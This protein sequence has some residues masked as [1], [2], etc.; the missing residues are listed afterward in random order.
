MHRRAD[1]DLEVLLRQARSGS[2]AARGE[3]LACY[4]NYLTL[5]ARL[6]LGRRLWARI[7]SAELVEETLRQAQRRFARFQGDT[8]VELVGWLRGI[9][10]ANLARL[11][12]R[13]RGTQR[14]GLD[15]A[16]QMALDLD[17]SS[18]TLHQTGAASQS[19][20]RPQSVRRDASVLLVDALQCL[21]DDYR[22]V[23]I[24]RQLEGLPFWAV[25]RRLGRP[26]ES[27][28]TLWIRA[29]DRLHGAL[30]DIP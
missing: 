24:L 23:I 22:E 30:R 11:L 12:R 10:A 21:P 19:A 1:T 2:A 6:Q 14:C 27:V 13:Y 20:P 17:Q 9:L 8:E 28:K 7:D 15:L 16:G 29:L 4:W 26:L 25:A 3:L 5:L 18:R